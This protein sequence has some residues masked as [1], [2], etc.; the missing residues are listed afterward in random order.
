MDEP[1]NLGWARKYIG[2]KGLGARY[3]FGLLKPGTAPLSPDNPFLIITGPLT[4][5]LAPSGWV[6]LSKW[7]DTP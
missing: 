5:T 1:L 7:I 6:R 2:G 4:G 3:L